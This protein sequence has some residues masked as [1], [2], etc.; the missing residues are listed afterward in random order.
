MGGDVVTKIVIIGGILLM[1][2]VV[3][4]AVAKKKI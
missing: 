3:A 2:A 4:W 1:V